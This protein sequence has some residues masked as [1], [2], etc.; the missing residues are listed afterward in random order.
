MLQR[1]DM[2]ARRWEDAGQDSG[3]MHPITRRGF[4]SPQVSAI[5]RVHSMRK[6]GR[7]LQRVG[8]L[9]QLEIPSAPSAAVIA[10]N[11]MAF[12]PR[13]GDVDAFNSLGSTDEQRLQA[14]VEQ[15]LHPSSIPDPE[16][17]LRLS[18]GGFTTLNKSFSKLWEDHVASSPEWKERIRPFWEVELATFIRAVYSTRQ[19]QEVLADFWHNHFN[20]YGYDYWVAPVFV[21]YDRDVIRAHLLGN[22]REMLEAVASSTEMLYYLDNYESRNSG[23]N[24]NYARELFELHTL[25]A[26]NYLGVMQQ[27]EVPKDGQGRP[28]G[29]VD[30][31]VF[32]AARCFTGWT[33][34]HKYPKEESTGL[35]EYRSDWHDRFQKHVLGVFI[36]QDQPDLKDGRDVLDALAEHPGTG[37]F[38]A[39]KLCRRL[40]ADDPPQSIVDRAAEVFRSERNAPDQLAQVVRTILLSDEFISTWGEKIKRPFEIAAS[41]LR[42]A[43]ADMPFEYD[44]D[45]KSF[46]YLYD[47]A[48]QPL[49]SWRPPDGYSDLREDWQSAAPR[50]M[51]WRLCNWLIDAHDDND[52]FYLDVLGQTP[53]DRRTAKELADFW[54]ERL[55]GRSMPERERLEI[56]DFM[57][58][59]HNPDNDLPVSRDEYTQDRL[60]AMVGLI[61]MSP[62]FLWR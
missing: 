59:G 21:H 50:I 35:F 52:A 51:S 53:S 40:I 11:R 7:V 37:R 60:R 4:L 27:H 20:V 2:P 17:A 1:K 31:D 49:F 6:P 5:E 29:Y 9:R 55:L 34:N 58:Q 14:Y 25:G 23:P 12:G 36:P 32:E 33:F 22:F 46:F 43:N 47:Q 13:P 3:R 10:L 44:G 62:S 56:V 54:I 61:F 19:L 18:R 57:A 45:H 38:I 16:A 15:Q 48:G 42:A 26:E 8:R 30:A 41:A 39:S 24:E 28:I